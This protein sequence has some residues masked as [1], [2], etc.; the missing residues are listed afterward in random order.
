MTSYPPPVT[1]C[2]PPQ[3][4]HNKCLLNSCGAKLPETIPPWEHLNP[5]IQKAFT[6][7][8]DEQTLAKINWGVD[9]TL[10]MR[11]VQQWL[12]KTIEEALERDIAKLLD[13]N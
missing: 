6:L 2:K 1:A 4:A 9:R 8:T 7:R 10:G 12:R 5:K 3:G 13:R 11:S